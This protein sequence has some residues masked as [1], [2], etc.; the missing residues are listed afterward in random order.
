MS[1]F[2]KLF[3]SNDEKKEEEEIKAK[4]KAINAKKKTQKEAQAQENIEIEKSIADLE[5][6]INTF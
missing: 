4:E 3:G 2:A 1:F 6:K 5:E